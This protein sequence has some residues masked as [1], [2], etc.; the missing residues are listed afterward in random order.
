MS[1]YICNLLRMSIR[2][3]I[4]VLADRNQAGEVEKINLDS[5]LVNDFI[6]VFNAEIDRMQ[7][8]RDEFREGI[9]G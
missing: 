6:V 2:Q 8:E 1:D 3:I 9:G 7:R 4:G 5:L